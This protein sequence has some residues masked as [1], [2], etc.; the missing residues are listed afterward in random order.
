MTIILDNLDSTRKVI[1][2]VDLIILHGGIVYIVSMILQLH[3]V[4]GKKEI[5]GK[6]CIHMLASKTSSWVAE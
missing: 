2:S 1:V 5:I 3:I 4:R 6:L